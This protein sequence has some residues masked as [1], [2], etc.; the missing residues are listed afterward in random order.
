MLKPLTVETR[1]VV[2]VSN[3]LTGSLFTRDVLVKTIEVILDLILRFQ[4][5]AKPSELC[6]ENGETLQKNNH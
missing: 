5:R 6:Q 4:F 2:S 3:E 1:N